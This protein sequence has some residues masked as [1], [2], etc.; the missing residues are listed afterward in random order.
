MHQS[1]CL[2]APSKRAHGS[3]RQHD[4][5]PSVTL[6][7]APTSFRLS[8]NCMAPNSRCSSGWASKAVIA[9]G[10]RWSATPPNRG[11]IGRIPVSGSRLIRYC[12]VRRGRFGTRVPKRLCP[13][14]K[15]FS[16]TGRASSLLSSIP[17]GCRWPRA[18]CRGQRAWDSIS[19]ARNSSSGCSVPHQRTASADSAS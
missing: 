12:F 8:F 10:Q 14:C 18:A 6:K 11:M 17:E 1:A 7:Q 19:V 13:G 9:S 16:S 5:C 15:V 2:S 3:L 4:S